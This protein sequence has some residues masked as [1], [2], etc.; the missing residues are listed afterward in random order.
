[1]TA[2]VV[3]PIVIELITRNLVIT[4]IAHLILQVL[5]AVTTHSELSA[6][7]WLPAIWQVTASAFLQ[8]PTMPPE[9]E[10]C[11]SKGERK[12]GWGEWLFRKIDKLSLNSKNAS[13]T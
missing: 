12:A 10:G 13:I 7:V 1:M 5:S 11:V 9:L 4:A 3:M 8:P 6:L 2:L